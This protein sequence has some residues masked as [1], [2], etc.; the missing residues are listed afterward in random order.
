[1][2]KFVEK[3]HKVRYL[4]DIREIIRYGAEHFADRPAFEDRHF[5]GQGDRR[6][7]SY[8][9][10]MEDVDALGTALLNRGL[11]GKKI[12]VMSENR[13]DWALTYFAV[14]CGVGVIIP[15]DRELP[16]AELVNLLKRAE[17]SALVYSKKQQKTVD[18]AMAELDF[19]EYLIEMDGDTHQWR[20]LS[21]K[22]LVEEGYALMA[23]GDDRYRSKEIDP[24]ALMAIYFTSGTTGTSKGVMLS[25]RNL[26]SNVENMLR[27]MYIDTTARGLLVLP[28]HH[29]FAFTC[30]VL[31]GMAGGAT[32]VIADGLKYIQR[33]LKEDRVNTMLG[34][35]LIYE[36]FHR[37]I[38]I[39][40]R[41]KGMEEKLKKGMRLNEK[42]QKFGMDRS[43]K[44]FK[45]IY[46]LIGND[47][48]TFI[49]GGA[50]MDPEIIRDFRA[51]G[52]NMF[53]GYGL[54]ETS[55]IIA[56]N[57]DYR[58]KTGTA[59]PP[60]PGTE[61]R[62][63]DPDEDGIGEIQTRS[64]SVMLGYYRDPEETEKVMLPD[65]W[66][67]TGDYG[68]MDREG[69]LHVTGRKKNVIVTKNG[70]NIYPEE[71]EY[72]LD[73][74]DYIKESVVWGKEDPDGGDLKI[75]AEI[76]IDPET[77]KGKTPEEIRSLIEEEVERVN[78]ATTSYKRIKRFNI[79][80]EEFEKTTTQK[81]RR[82]TIDLK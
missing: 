70:K 17:A 1:M 33:N 62:I 80:E 31:P 44:M 24:H 28:V 61:V 54:T 51:L 68:F 21:L 36:T 15:L 6:A 37:K 23:E 72:L 53:E 8:R 20:N 30:E 64:E 35:P 78:A 27:R 4:P 69:F 59:G 32:I 49:V 26:T 45:D 9:Q 66:F 79:R 34:V 48:R 39:A 55:P 57:A 73:K 43:R 19:V 38:L 16:S 67:A 41:H 46:D 25:H 29:T 42:L 13:Y 65:G 77:L 12:A 71:L 5:P 50:P 14:S 76:V 74:S 18:A 40:A 10:V 11:E 47:I 22:K 2:A 56:V 60:M 63:A 7:I 52:V 82:H 58:Q 3:P 81:I 75:T